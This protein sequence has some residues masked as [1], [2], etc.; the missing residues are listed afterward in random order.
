MNDFLVYVTLVIFASGCIG[1]ILG[2]LSTQSKSKRQ[3]EEAYLQ[4]R[5]EAETYRLRMK[6]ELRSE[7]QVVRESIVE[8]LD[9]YERALERV[10]KRLAE[11]ISNVLD[12]SVLGIGSAD[13]GRIENS[14]TIA[15]R[16]ESRTGDRSLLE[17][18]VDSHSHNND[19]IAASDC[20]FGV[21]DSERGAG[22]ETGSEGRTDGA[23]NSENRSAF[24]QDYDPEASAQTMRDPHPLRSEIQTSET[25][26]DEPTL[27]QD[28]VDEK[29]SMV[30]GNAYHDP[31]TGAIVLK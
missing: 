28:A 27:E 11:P 3:V 25:D 5:E 2:L 7:L 9:T 14:R 20:L 12:A 16:L 23:M 1:F 13:A 15:G 6:D 8:T 21:E 31:R 26:D 29:S 24:A 18:S 4:G 30:N 10:E 19:K 22:N 17:T